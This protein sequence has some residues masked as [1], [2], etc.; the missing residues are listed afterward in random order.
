VIAGQSKGVAA[1][2]VVALV[3]AGIAVVAN[4]DEPEIEASVSA[5]QQMLAWPP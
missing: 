1:A 5:L 2:F 3:I 4:V